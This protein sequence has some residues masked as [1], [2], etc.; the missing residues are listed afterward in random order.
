MHLFA[1]LRVAL[2]A[3]WVHKGRS[4]LTSLGIII[5][6]GCVIAMVSAGDGV[7]Q[8]LD[9]SM[10]SVGKNLIVV[11]PGARSRTGVV[12]DAT[13]LTRDDAALVRKQAGP[14]LKGVAEVEPTRRLARSAAA[15]WPT[16]VTG[17]VPDLQ[18]VRDWKTVSGRFFTPEE[19]DEAANVCVVGQ[20]VRAKL[21]PGDSNPLG[22]TIHVDKLPLRV[23]GV[24]AAK[25]RNPA[26]GDQDDEIFTPITTLQRKLAEDHDIGSILATARTP[27]LLK[28]AQKA[29]AEALRRSHRVEAGSEDFDVSTVQEMVE[30]AYVLTDAVQE[31][32][33]VIASMSLLVGGI[34]IMNIMLVSVTERTRE[35]GLRM[36]VGATSG[37]ILTQ[38]LIEAMALAVMGG[39]LGVLTGLSVAAVLAQALDWPLVISPSIV[40]LAVG[41]SAAVGVFFGFYPAWRASRLDPIEALRY[42]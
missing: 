33:A 1:T 23:V 37:H 38:F 36:A 7:Q 40:L 5:G 11:R 14:F 30:V 20:T 3:L 24:L 41:V 10:E 34:G 8:K 29:V 4:V 12:S 16:L 27:A 9:E 42:E 19:T 32:V 31:L 26:G 17:T 35:I 25:G 13:P 18:A 2:R 39:I 15:N 21:F 22:Q 6:I 28:P